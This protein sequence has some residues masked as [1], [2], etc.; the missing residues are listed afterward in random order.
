[1]S[2]PPPEVLAEQPPPGV[3]AFA[4]VNVAPLPVTPAGAG[5]PEAVSIPGNLRSPPVTSVLHHGG[6]PP[7]RG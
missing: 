7:G 1:M 3:K 2:A 5:G 6:R 4:Y